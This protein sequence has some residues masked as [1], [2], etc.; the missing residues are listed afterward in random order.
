M[1][2]DGTKLEQRNLE[3]E[4]EN[5]GTWNKATKTGIKAWTISRS[6]KIAVKDDDTRSHKQ[7][8]WQITL[9]LDIKEDICVG[10]SQ[11]DWQPSKTDRSIARSDA[12]PQRHGRCHF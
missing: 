3:L 8:A 12:I 6:E 7:W 5:E 2:L 10:L 4:M 11:K 1:R 9:Q